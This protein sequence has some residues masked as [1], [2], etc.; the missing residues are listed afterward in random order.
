V[1]YLLEV[2]DLEIDG[3]KHCV[4]LGFLVRKRSIV[5]VGGLLNFRGIFQFEGDMNGSWVK[6]S[7]IKLGAGS[8]KFFQSFLDLD[9]SFALVITEVLDSC[10]E[11]LKD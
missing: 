3:S 7:I 10:S 4:L 6:I 8:R 2:L 1:C 5:T 11:R 9:K